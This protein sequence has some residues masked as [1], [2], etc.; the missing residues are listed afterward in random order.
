MFRRNA[1]DIDYT[2]RQRAVGDRDRGG[3]AAQADAVS[4]GIP[5]PF[6]VS[7]SPRPCEVD[8]YSPSPPLRKV[9]MLVPLTM[10]LSALF[11][12]WP[13]WSHQQLAR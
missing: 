7:G 12:G 3:Q 11:Q 2:R 5:W 8:Q 13:S 4:V 1:V 10:K 6:K 9:G